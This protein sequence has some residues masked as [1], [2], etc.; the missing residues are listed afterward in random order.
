MLKEIELF[1]S[2]RI[3]CFTLLHV[4]N[5]QFEELRVSFSLRLREG[6]DETFYPKQL[7]ESITRYLSPWAFAN[8]SGPSFGGK[9]YKSSLINFIEE[10]PCVDYITDFILFRDETEVI[11][12]AAEGSLSVSVLVSVPADRHTITL[13]QT[14]SDTV[15]GNTC[16]CEA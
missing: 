6:Y 12:D 11:T 3:S 7:Q 1:I 13:I 2:K 4:R 8:G 10:Q 15:S 16:A 5:P 14:T 9:V